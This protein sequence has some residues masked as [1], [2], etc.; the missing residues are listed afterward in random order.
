LRSDEVRTFAR[1]QADETALLVVGTS[2]S[3]RAAAD[4]KALL[5][6]PTNSQIQARV[7]ADMTALATVPATRLATL[8][9]DALNG[10]LGADLTNLVSANPANTA[11][12]THASTFESGGAAAAAIGNVVTVAGTFANSTGTLNADVNST[13]TGSTIPN[14]VGTY[15]GS[16]ISSSGTDVGKVNPAAFDVTNEGADGS[17]T[18]TVT[19]TNDGNPTFFS[20]SGSVTADGSFTAT[21]VD[22]T[23][24]H[25]NATLTGTASRTTISGTG[26]DGEG[27]TS[28]FALSLQ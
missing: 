14:L 4:G 18:G 1:L 23:A 27:N 7:T 28:T 17:L 10:T 19:L 25:P 3:A 20:L 16:F 21:L 9:A 6:H 5:L 24:Q 15:G 11:L 2:L 12:A 8:Q 26:D 22:P 13:T